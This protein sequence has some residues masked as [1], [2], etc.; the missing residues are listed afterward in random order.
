MKADYR[1][2]ALLSLVF[3]A[4]LRRSELVALDVADVQRVGADVFAAADP[5]RHKKLET[6]RGYD[7]RRK[8][9]EPRRQGVPMTDKAAVRHYCLLLALKYAP[10]ELTAL[11][12]WA[13]ALFEF[14]ERAT[15]NNLAVEIPRT[16]EGE[17]LH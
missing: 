6:T 3:A 2:R 1:D 16:A 7:Q 10:R 9:L 13:E 5:A 17:T 12:A 14:L 4:A 11:L 15:E 8:V